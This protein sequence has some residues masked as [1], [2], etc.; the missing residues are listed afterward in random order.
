MKQLEVFFEKK[1]FHWLTAK[2][3]NG[4]I[5]SILRSEKFSLGPGTEAKF[6]F[7]KS[8]RSYRPPCARECV[9]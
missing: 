9:R 5:G 6:V 1:Y 8:L 3:I 2:I 4:L 7:R